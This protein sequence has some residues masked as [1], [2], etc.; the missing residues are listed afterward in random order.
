MSEAIRKL[1]KL[2]SL[3]EA[4]IPANPNSPKNLRLRK[5]M[6]GDMAK[7]F[8]ALGIAFPYSKLEKIYNKYVEP[9]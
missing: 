8:S 9:D 3:M 1:N 6:E 5:R 7:Y 4:E 2:I